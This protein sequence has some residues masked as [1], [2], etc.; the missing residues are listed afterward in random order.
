MAQTVAL[1]LDVSTDI[2]WFDAG[3]NWFSP[4][5][6]RCSELFLQNALNAQV[7]G[8][9]LISSD[10]EETRHNIDYCQ[11]A[12]YDMTAFTM[13]GV[14]PHQ[15]DHVS[16]DWI[17]QLDEFAQ[18]PQ[19]R[20][21]GECG[22]DFHRMY[23]SATQQELVFRQQLLTAIQWQKAVYLHE[24]EAFALQIAILTE[25]NIQ[26]GIAHTFTG[27]TAQLRAYLD[28]GLYIGITGWLCDER[29]NHD[30]VTALSFIPADRMILETDAPYLMPRTLRPRPK[31]GHNEPAFLPLVAHEVARLTG[32]SLVDIAQ[33]QLNNCAQLLGVEHCI[34]PA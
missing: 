32:R 16:E 20:L 4:A 2:R 1:R 9:L 24:R 33:Q 14:H 28:L 26:H 25:H 10:L 34:K 6:Q 27:T 29:R 7:H 11:Q 8:M 3:V 31:H 15:A 18:Q 23:S 17:Q 12:Q 5:L 19:V 30:L 21:I 13:A 22:L